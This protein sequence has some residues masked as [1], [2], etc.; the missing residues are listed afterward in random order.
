MGK[1]NSKK[2]E[3]LC[4]ERIIV[5][6]TKVQKHDIE[7]KAATSGL[8]VSAYVRK[9]LTGKSPKLRMTEKEIAALNSFTDAR[10]DV[11]RLFSFLKGRP[12]EE[13]KKYFGNRNFVETWMQAVQKVIDR[14]VE[15]EKNIVE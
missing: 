5:R 10:G 13:R 7:N 11:V 12:A 1:R 4:T 8:T 3:P 15:I 14:M 6:L 9:C 2:E